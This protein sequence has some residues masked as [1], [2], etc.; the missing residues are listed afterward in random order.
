[1]DGSNVVDINYDFD[2]FLSLGGLMAH[3]VDREQNKS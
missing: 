2:P 1:M 3:G